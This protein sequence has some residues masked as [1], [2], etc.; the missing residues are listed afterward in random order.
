MIAVDNPYAREIFIVGLLLAA[1][2]DRGGCFIYALD[3]EL[4]H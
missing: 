2:A 4:L 3:R 1:T